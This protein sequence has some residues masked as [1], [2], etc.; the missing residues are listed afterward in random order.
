[1]RQ[2]RLSSPTHLAAGGTHASA[3]ADGDQLLVVAEDVG[4]HNTLDKIRGECLFHGI[5]T[6]DRI[7]L[8]TGRISSEMVSKAVKMEVPIVASRSTPTHL[9]VKLA[10]DWQ[11]TVVGYVR[12]GK[13]NVYSRPDRVVIR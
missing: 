13:M 11:M 5:P 6:K 1:M 4:R 2:L 9:A 12:G 10:R 8:T 3:L 7:L